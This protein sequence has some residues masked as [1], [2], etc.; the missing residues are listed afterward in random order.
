MRQRVLRSEGPTQRPLL[1]SSLNQ[2][3]TFNPLQPLGCQ[4]T[5]QEQKLNDQFD[6]RDENAHRARF[7]G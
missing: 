2:G 3:K 1:R 7:H 6:D 4:H 5:D